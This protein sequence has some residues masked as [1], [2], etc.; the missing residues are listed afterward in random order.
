MYRLVTA[1]P[2]NATKACGRMP[3]KTAEQAVSAWMEK[4]ARPVQTLVM[5]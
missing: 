1:V 5:A 4:T 2:I 3:A